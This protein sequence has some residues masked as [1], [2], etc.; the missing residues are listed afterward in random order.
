MDCIWLLVYKKKE[1][2]LNE[3][4]KFLNLLANLCYGD[5]TSPQNKVRCCIIGWAIDN[6]NDFERNIEDGLK[7]DKI[8]S[9]S[10]KI[11]KSVAR[12]FMEKITTELLNLKYLIWCLNLVLPKSIFSILTLLF[13][14][15]CFKFNRYSWTYML[16]WFFY[17][18]NA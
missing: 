11:R 17:I 12:K 6:V 18:E 3:W 4:M 5:W 10:W 15:I 2:E 16:W 14:K 13:L 7:S 1:Y 9:C 8:W